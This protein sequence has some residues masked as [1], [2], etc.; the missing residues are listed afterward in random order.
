MFSGRV[1]C[2]G[3]ITRP[4]ESYRMCVC[5]CVCVSLSL[6]GCNNHPLH[7]RRVRVRGQTKEERKIF[8]R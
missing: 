1:A 3:P 4:K 7:L 6:I 8:T 5:V 2:D